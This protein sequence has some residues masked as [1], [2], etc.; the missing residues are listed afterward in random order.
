MIDLAR[1]ENIR[2]IFY[3][4]EIDS[5]Q[6]EAFAEELGGQ[7]VQLAP[8]R[9]TISPICRIWRKLWQR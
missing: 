1:E 9:R 2:A 4:E 3:Q 7:T 8:L 6:S 5:S